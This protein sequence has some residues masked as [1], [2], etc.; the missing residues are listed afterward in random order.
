METFK[1]EQGRFSLTPRTQRRSQNFHSDAAKIDIFFITSKLLRQKMHIS[2][3]FCSLF[4]EFFVL[5]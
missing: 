5:L 1:M 4:Q 2:P 3:L